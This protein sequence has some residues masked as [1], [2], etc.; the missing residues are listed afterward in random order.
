MVFR[1]LYGTHTSHRAAHAEFVG[2]SRVVHILFAD[3]G[4]H[5]VMTLAQAT[6][7]GLVDVEVLL[8][9]EKF[10][11]FAEAN[12]VFGSIGWLGMELKLVTPAMLEDTG[13]RCGKEDFVLLEE[14]DVT[15]HST[16]NL[17]QLASDAPRRR[18]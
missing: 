12:I 16:L 11:V 6:S 13:T 14:R 8:D 17:T 3:K 5:S 18:G 2:E 7:N 4:F 9:E 10:V 15:K 1:A